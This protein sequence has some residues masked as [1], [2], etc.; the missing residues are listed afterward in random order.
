MH[1]FFAERRACGRQVFR[2][3]IPFMSLL[4]IT[5]LGFSFTLHIA[6]QHTTSGRHSLIEGDPEADWQSIETSIFA[7]VN[8]GLYSV[9]KEP[10]MKSHWQATKL[11]DSSGACIFTGRS[12]DH[13]LNFRSCPDR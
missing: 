3:I 6:L 5:T 9:F 1:S 4:L 2:E 8:M 7:S 10:P 13:A 11:D 12:L